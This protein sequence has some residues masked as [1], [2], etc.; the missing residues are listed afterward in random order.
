MMDYLYSE[1]YPLPLGY[2]EVYRD[3]VSARI[4]NARDNMVAELEYATAQAEKNSNQQSLQRLANL[5]RYL[6]E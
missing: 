5:Y 4:S 6:S 3:I 2:D 1:D